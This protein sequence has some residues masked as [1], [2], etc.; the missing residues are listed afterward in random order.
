MFYYLFTGIVL[1]SSYFFLKIEAPAIISTA[2]LTKYQGWKALNDL[3]ATQQ[4]SKIT[5]IT[6]SLGMIAEA[7]YVSLSAYLNGHIKQLDKS[8]YE[9]SYVIKGNLYKMVVKPIRQPCPLIKITNSKDE[10]VTYKI[11]PYYG[12]RY[13]W[14]HH[15]Y[16][17]KFFGEEKLVFEYE[18]ETT[19]TFRD[20]EHMC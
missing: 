15:Q 1:A 7:L 14:H 12:P 16:T 2:I 8:H 19:K 3:V 11:L 10:D 17:P 9:V 5:I 6:I 4:T 13:N 20:A 18:D